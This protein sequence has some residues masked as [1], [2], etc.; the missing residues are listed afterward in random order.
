MVKEVKA[1]QKETKVFTYEVKM[2]VSVFDTNEKSAQE[3][4]DRDG[5]FVSSREISLLDAQ[6]II[7]KN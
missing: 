7:S 6:S 2:I 4:L 3:K 1:E 5:G